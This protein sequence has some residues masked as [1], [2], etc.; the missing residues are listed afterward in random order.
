MFH[1]LKHL[2]TTVHNLRAGPHQPRCMC[3]LDGNTLLYEDNSVNPLEIRLGNAHN[4]RVLP[5][6]GNGGSVE[7]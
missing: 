6:T 5:F 4:L 7:Q 1:D 2:T 3:A